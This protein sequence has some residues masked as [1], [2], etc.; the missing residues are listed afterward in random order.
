MMTVAVNEFLDDLRGGRMTE[1]PTVSVQQG[2]LQGRTV[3]SPSGKAFYS[4]QGIPYAKPPLG[5][6]RFKAPQPAESW[7][8]VRDATSEGSVCPQIDPIITKQFTGDENCLYLNIY[9]PNLDGAFLPVMIYIH[10]GGFRNGSGS[11]SLYGADFLVEKDVVVVTI[12]YR[13]GALGFLSLNTPEVPGNAGLKDIVQA[14]RWI[15]ENIH[16]FGGN[17]GNLTVFG[18]SGGGVATAIL[19]ASPSTKDLISKAIIQSGTAINHAVYQKCPISNAKKLVNIL[20]GEAEDVDDI[21]EFLN[22]TSAK[23]LVEATEKLASDGVEFGVTI[24][25]EFGDVEAVLTESFYDVLTS[26]RVADIPIMIGSTSLELTLERK[27]DDLQDL[28][29]EELHI[30]RNSEQSLEIAEGI[31]SLYFKGSHTGVESLNE[32]LELLSDTMINIHTH[33]HVKY[34]VQ[35]SNK[36]VYYYKFDYVGELNWSKKLLAS[37]GLNHAGHLDE[38]G[39]L[40]SNEMIKDVEA[41]PQDLKMRE[42]M[43]RLWTN[44]AKSGNPT[45]EENYYLTV[46]W[47]PVTHD[48]LYFLNLGSELS[49]GSNPDKA[50]MDFWDEVYTKYFRIWDQ[51][52]TNTEEAV[53]KTDI[54][55]SVTEQTPVAYQEEIVA[56]SVEETPVVTNEIIVVPETTPEEPLVQISETPE[57]VKTEPVI[58]DEIEV[59]QESS[60]VQ[61][62]DNNGVDKEEDVHEIEPTPVHISNGNS[63]EVKKPRT[64]NEI[65][66]VQQPNG[67]PKD[68]IRANDPPEDDLPKNIGVNKF[69]NFFESLGG[70]K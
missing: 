13:L 66:M 57:P 65:K 67:T 20:C 51:P 15:K 9:T 42:R 64:S 50:K 21:L 32:Y 48:N 43:V 47:L 46:T 49:L 53:R 26:G 56:V 33:R 12:N 68:V 61:V 30:E 69:V 41:T 27:S 8:G 35:V 44:F 7:D 6:F 54:I 62:V 14:I 58:V 52:R 29:P 23:E 1:A 37:L 28:I 19:T 4:F 18:E 38:L 70:K 22:A 3:N 2:Q 16:N 39:Y 5:S 63:N 36:P 34:L 45:P 59:V 10:G 24:E 17:S 40:F 25:K 55:I 60:P 11:A 31:K